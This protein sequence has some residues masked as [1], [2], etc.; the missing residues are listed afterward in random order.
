MS[1]FSIPVEVAKKRE[2][3]SPY[4]LTILVWAALAVGQMVR[5]F[6]AF[7]HSIGSTDDAMR[8]FQIRQWLS[9]SGWY[10]LFTDRFN[11]PDG[12]HTHWSRLIDVPIAGMILLLKPVF[13][14]AK[15]VQWTLV[16]WPLI[17]L[18][19]VYCGLVSIARRLAGPTSSIP[20]IAAA[21]ACMPGQYIFNPGEIDHHNMQL[22]F[23][24]GLVAFALRAQ[25]SLV[26]AI[27]GGVSAALL[28][29]IGFESLHVFG[30][31]G[32]YLV[33]TGLIDTNS[34][35]SS[36]RFFLILSLSMPVV[37]LAN[38]P[39]DR[40]LTPRCD[41]LAINT[42]T[43]VTIA[44]SGLAILFYFASEMKISR[45][46][47]LV[48]VIST[49]AGVI[50]LILGPVCRAGPLAELDTQLYP[51]WLSQVSEARNIWQLG[52]DPAEA[53]GYFAIGIFGLAGGVYAF[54]R[55]KA[56]LPL[57]LLVL[58]VI[59]SIGLA[60]FQIR[61]ITYVCWFGVALA[62]VSWCRTIP[63]SLKYAQVKR[64]LV[65]AILPLAFVFLFDRLAVPQTA[66]SAGGIRSVRSP[67]APRICADI[68]NFQAIAALPEGIILSHIDLGSYLL[69]E[70]R[71]KVV[72]APYHR[73]EKAII[74][75]QSAF[76]ASI[77]DAQRQIAAYPAKIDYIV[78]C[79]ALPFG[80]A[81]LAEVQMQK[82]GRSTYFRE[83]LVKSGKVDWLEAVPMPQDNPLKVWRIRP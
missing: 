81:E 71:H 25:D 13:G 36:G 1:P 54:L 39:P 79:A 17:P 63:D 67:D 61:S 44:A 2:G 45:K 30:L 82:S 29:A 46:I 15:A 27:L 51:L 76:A 78:D 6:H 59:S 22:M 73:A 38:V 19:G 34:R 21:V 68:R 55:G 83:A 58:L 72:M 69:A 50:F 37:F 42:A 66:E 33:V 75:G 3:I 64:I 4:W 52:K 23:S 49:I 31:V 56:D 5:D 40:W 74:F 47:G 14:M 11:P 41:A 9:G 8:L 80:A 65:I 43:A 62:T 16:I 48:C 18:A 35:I 10:G 53:L 60:F 12:Y 32:L 24:I 20:M 28:L 77:N 70:T 57:V 26:A 7:D